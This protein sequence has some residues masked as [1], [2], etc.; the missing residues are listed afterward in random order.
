MHPDTWS[1]CLA[2]LPHTAMSLEVRLTL[3]PDRGYAIAMTRGDVVKSFFR[4]GLVSPP[5]HI[6]WIVEIAYEQVP[7][8]DN[9]HGLSFKK[10]NESPLAKGYMQP[11]ANVLMAFFEARLPPG[12]R[13][14][15]T[16]RGNTVRE[17]LHED[18]NFDVEEAY[19]QIFD[20]PHNVLHDGLRQN[21][22]LRARVRGSI[23]VALTT[24]I[25]VVSEPVA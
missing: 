16:S 6:H 20:V 3:G 2:F 19:D 9:I 24:G 21:E 11:V 1:G 17:T 15:V 5:P 25:V 12:T 4:P 23:R 22:E 13:L 10:Q 8:A 7:A 14:T 18:P